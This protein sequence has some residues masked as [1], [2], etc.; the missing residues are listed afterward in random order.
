MSPDATL[1]DSLSEWHTIRPGKP[2]LSLSV[3][4]ITSVSVTFILSSTFSDF[5]AEAEPFLASL[6]LTAEDNDNDEDD[7]EPKKPSVISEVLAKGLSVNVNSATWKN[8]YIHIDEKT[9][10]A[11]III[12]NLMPGKKYD[13]D[14]GLVQGGRSNNIRRQV[15]TD[16]APRASLLRRPSPAPAASPP[17]T[18]TRTRNSPPK[19]A[20]PSSPTPS[21]S[22]PPSAR[23]SPRPSSPRGATPSAPT[24]PCAPEIDA[25]RRGSEK[26]A[27]A[28]A[29]ARQKVLALQEAVKRAQ[30]A[31]RE[32]E[33]QMR[34]VEGALPGLRS[35]RAAR[36]E[37]YERIRG[38]ADRVRGERAQG[39]ERE[40][41]RLEG[42]RG[43][44]TGLGNRVERLGG[45]REKLEGGVIPD[46]EAQLREIEL[47]IER[48]E[49]DPWAPRGRP[50]SAMASRCRAFLTR[51]SPIP[52]QRP[53]QTSSS[54]SGSAF[55]Q[56]TAPA[57]SRPP[58]ARV[59]HRRRR[60]PS[61]PPRTNAPPPPARPRPPVAPPRPSPSRSGTR[62]SRTQ[63]P[64]S[65]STDP[66][67]SASLNPSPTPASAVAASTLSSRA[68]PFEPGRISFLASS[69]SGN[70]WPAPVSTG[71]GNGAHG[72]SHKW[73][74]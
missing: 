10:E 13:I 46:L 24:P 22:L 20:S 33:E 21:P 32:V 36:E 70:G 6:G 71:R 74:S 9:D 4:E 43:E 45:K 47:E 35:E 50:R 27:A 2:P 52:I 18:R 23:P 3:R 66:S 17:R 58:S 1:L 42:L 53:G 12:Y 56:W 61:T 68:A 8:V 67:A 55:P 38:E 39:E 25:I 16:A 69:A 59:Q 14:L 48:A 51:P 26:H 41:R 40:R 5:G 65:T 37:A 7:R 30:T 62:R 19:T 11:V 54:A 57:P 29:R 73:G 15:V 49:A 60:P 72:Q 31:T 34:E 44:L 28:E 63:S 64:R